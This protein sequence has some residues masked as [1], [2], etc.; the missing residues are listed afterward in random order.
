[1]TCV[2]AEP[3]GEEALRQRLAAR[4]VPDLKFKIVSDPGHEMLNG[5]P[6]IFVTGPFDW[7]VSGPYTL[8]QPALVV[9]GLPECSWSWK[10]MGYG[11][12]TELDEVETDF[13]DPPISKV[14]LVTLRPIFS[15]LLDAI[16]EKR[17]PKLASTHRQVQDILK[18]DKEYLV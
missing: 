11:D 7:E 14:A 13:S 12:K 17:P 9:D 16:K 15:D 6:D 2:T 4:G 3:G 5:L 18:D 10:T 1:M 8:I